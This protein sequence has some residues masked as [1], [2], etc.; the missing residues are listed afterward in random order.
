MISV[1]NSLKLNG[2]LQSP[3]SWVS[4]IGWLVL[5][6]FS[7][8]LTTRSSKAEKKWQLEQWAFF[9]FLLALTPLV[10]L[11]QSSILVKGAILHP[12]TAGTTYEIRSFLLLVLPWMLASVYLGALPAFFLSLVSGGIQAIFFSHSFAGIVEIGLI[13]SL[14]IFLIRQNYRGWLFQFLRVPLIC[15]GVCALFYPVIHLAVFLL[16]DAGAANIGFLLFTLKY[17][18]FAFLLQ[19]FTSGLICSVSLLLNPTARESEKDP[20]PSPFEKSF[21]TRVF[22]IFVVIVTLMVMMIV[23]GDWL[24]ATNLSQTNLESDLEHITQQI[25]SQVP[26]VFNEGFQSMEEASNTISAM[27]SGVLVSDFLGTYVLANSAFEKLIL[28]DQQDQIIQVLANSSSEEDKIYL[29]PVEMAAIDLASQGIQN[30]VYIL[31]N[32]DSTG[33]VIL[34]FVEKAQ[35][36]TLCLSETCI[37][38][39]YLSI[40]ESEAGSELFGLIQEVEDAN[41]FVVIM[42]SSGSILFRSGNYL[43]YMPLN[44]PYFQNGLSEYEDE[45]GIHQIIYS[46]M[47]EDMDWKIVSAYPKYMIFDS[48][49]QIIFPHLLLIFASIVMGGLILWPLLKYYTEKLEI[50]TTESKEIAEGR[51][52]N[53][54]NIQ[55]DDEIG[56]LAATFRDMQRRLK[57][58]FDEITRILSITQ[59]VSSEMDLDQAIHPVLDELLKTGAETVRIYLPGIQDVNSGENQSYQYGTGKYADEYQ[60]FDQQLMEFILR[61]KKTVIQ[62]PLR[63]GLKF[64]R[65][66]DIRLVAL[67]MMEESENK[68][69]LWATYPMY[70]EFSEAIPRFMSTIAQ[71]I[72][73]AV[74]NI[75]SYKLADSGKTYMDQILNTVSVPIL[76]VDK[77]NHLRFANPS[78]AIFLQNSPG[79]DLGKPIHLALN[80]PELI[81]QLE[82]R[83]IDVVRNEIKHGPSGLVFS[84]HSAPIFTNADVDGRVCV[85]EN[86]TTYKEMDRAKS[87]FISNVSQDLKTPLTKIKSY[88]VMLSMVGELNQEQDEYTKKIQNGMERMSELVNDLLDL[89]RIES[90]ELRLSK[91]A[92]WELIAPVVEDLT[93]VAS[94]RNMRLFPPEIHLKTMVQVDQA[95]YQRAVQNIVDNA[96]HYSNPE[97]DIRIVTSEEG[98]YVRFQV[99]D[100]GIGISTVDLPHIFE[101]FFR[102]ADKKVQNR[103]GIGLGLSIAKSIIESHGGSISAESQLGK[104]TTISFT[105]PKRQK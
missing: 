32:S 4:W 39:G 35:N 105:L 75:Q 6:G 82:L 43:N 67:Q 85:L 87:E 40:F 69:V 86:V 23:L 71:Q 36:S 38:I 79:V 101:S 80:S 96:I 44:M 52:D 20:V 27:D 12:E 10:N 104:G 89:Q 3:Q 54:I 33:N 72:S 94:Q 78:A 92:V 63:A 19:M 26:L 37:M 9:G 98:E 2:Y 18:I 16:G 81:Q 17:S 56:Q 65:N 1:I 45:S 7:I 100:Q 64:H 5:F 31:E 103:K 47:S 34:F 30:Q 99:I 14:Y 90:G 51:L 57:D 77:A 24:F 88:L 62:N 66:P 55:G 50:L 46:Q 25:T 93:P 8:W 42:N 95:L 84:V 22:S 60:V 74:K 97:S 91:V 83:S 59:K 58:R 29:G 28:L 13:A 68:G 15:A 53:W 73:L 49:K 70:A 48:A 41:G 76:V 61:Q 21:L 102:S 11:L